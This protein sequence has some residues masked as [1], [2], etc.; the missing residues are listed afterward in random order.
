MMHQAHWS[1]A[2]VIHAWGSKADWLPSMKV[3][4]MNQ[5]EG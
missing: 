1:E 4:V 3:V 5:F 2:Q